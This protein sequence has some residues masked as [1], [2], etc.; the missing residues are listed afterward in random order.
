MLGFPW[1]QWP[2][3][4]KPL[5]EAV[6]QP[7]TAFMHT[8][9]FPFFAWAA[10]LVDHVAAGSVAG[11]QDGRCRHEN[12]AV[13]PDEGSN[14]LRSVR[15][16]NGV[17][18]LKACLASFILLRRTYIE[19]WSAVFFLVVAAPTRANAL[20]QCKLIALQER[21]APSAVTH[22]ISTLHPYNTRQ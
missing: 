9:G 16:L 1:P 21:L 2:V 4:I 12:T 10:G 22:R 7:D 6:R 8:A 15:L 5:P 20:V 19:I 18:F 14:I 17:I 3:A 11:C 13:D